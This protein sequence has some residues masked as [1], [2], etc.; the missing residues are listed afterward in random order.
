MSDNTDIGPGAG[1][2]ST[3]EQATPVEPKRSSIPPWVWIIVAVVAVIAMIGLY[4]TQTEQGRAWMLGLRSMVAVPKV[5]GLTQSQAQTTLEAT[6]LRVGQV[7]QEPTLAVPPGTVVSQKPSAGSEVKKDSAVDI[8]VAAIPTVQVPNVVGQLQADAITAL[9]EEGLRTGTVNYVYDSNVPAGKVGAQTPSANE[10]VSVG[11]AVN[12]TVSMGNQQGQVPNV[13]GLSQDDAN[14][15]ITAAGFKVTTVKA[16]SANVPPGDVVAQ[17]PA[18]GVVTAA[19]STVTI[20]VSTGP[21]PAAAPAPPLRRLRAPAA[22]RAPRAHRADRAPTEPPATTVK[23]PDVVGKSVKDAVSALKAAKLKVSFAFASSETDVSEGHQAGPRVRGR[24]RSGLDGRHHDRPAEDQ[25]AG[26]QADAAHA[27]ARTAAGRDADHVAGRAAGRGATA[28]DADNTVG[29]P[30]SPCRTGH[31]E[32]TGMKHKTFKELELDSEGLRTPSGVMALG[33]LSTADFHRNTVAEPGTPGSQTASPAGVV[34][35]AVIGGVVAGPVGA[36]AGGLVGSAIKTDSP[37][38][39]G[40]NMT[41]SA[42]I[43]FKTT[44]LE[45]TTEVPVFDVED[46]E[47]F[48]AEVRSAAGLPPLA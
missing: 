7:S 38:E 25:P 18:A 29:S 5:V 45:Y 12:L 42:T 8:A 47:E 40:Y 17:S 15:V 35:G 36:V 37:G 4:S 13:I 14:S 32:R 26:W 39:P 23:V 34:G 31:R 27:A 16:A 48:V 46:A 19:G 43:S 2:D 11:S 44:A 24:G 41:T 6:G 20:T 28:V 30:P 33:D 22:D 9:A 21:T 3:P 1:T 10:K